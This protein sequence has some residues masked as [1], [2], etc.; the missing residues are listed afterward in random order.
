MKN[1]K[2]ILII[3]PLIVVAII[4]ILGLYFVTR[5][6]KTSDAIKFKKEY[7]TLNNTKTESGKTIRSITISSSNPII[8]KTEDEI[9][10]MINNKETFIVYFGFPSCPWCRSVLPNLLEA[11]K[12]L[13]LEKLYYVN[14]LDIRDKI[15]YKNGKLET[16]KRG[17]EGYYE[18]LKLLDNVLSDYSI[19]DDKGNEISAGEK[20]IYAPNVVGI[21][22]GKAEKLTEGISKKQTDAYMKL[23]RVMNKES[24]NDFKCVIKCVQEEPKVCS[25][26]AC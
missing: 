18:L 12:D 19:T 8:Y 21:V 13:K 17:S 10:E 1:K 14:V 4:L 9:V 6:K 3:I 26:K 15:E 20:R 2:K 23:T 7:E 11:A 22:S 16:T 5:T 24:Y 25:S